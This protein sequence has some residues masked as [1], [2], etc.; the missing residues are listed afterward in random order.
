MSKVPRRDRSFTKAF[1]LDF[2]IALVA[3]VGGGVGTSGFFAADPLPLRLLL[4]SLGVVWSA[5][6]FSATLAAAQTWILPL[7][8]FPSFLLS[9]LGTSLAYLAVI[10]VG[11]PLGAAGT[12]ALSAHGPDSLKAAFFAVRMVLRPE[13]VGIAFALMVCITFYFM[14]S[15]KLGPGVLK[16][17]MLGRYYRPRQESRVFMFLDIKDSTR[18][19]EELGDLKFSRL[20]Q[21]FFADLTGPVLSTKGEVSH[22]IGDEAVLTWKVGPKRDPGLCLQCYFELTELIAQRQSAYLADFG[23]VPKFKAGAH[24]GPV[25]ATQVGEIKSEVVFHGDVL[26]TT[27]RIQ[28][29]CNDLGSPLLVSEQLWAQVKDNPKFRFVHAGTHSVKGKVD[30]VVVYAVERVRP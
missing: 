24:V 30:S 9:V 2:P 20:I 27:S 15:K 11:I 4:I 25:I 19:G 23:V 14:L 28:S 16:N 1:A 29:L 5:I 6:V 21:E 10:V 13:M 3:S 18:L 8:R 22:Y 7:M 17:W 12:A 26:N